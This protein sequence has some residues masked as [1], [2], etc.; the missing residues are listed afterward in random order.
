M[1]QLRLPANSRI[2]TGSQ[3]CRNRSQ[4]R[5]SRRFGVS[6]SFRASPT[7]PAYATGSAAIPRTMSRYS[8]HRPC[9]GRVV[10]GAAVHGMLPAPEGIGRQRHQSADQ[11]E[12]S[13]AE[14]LSAAVTRWSS[15][16]DTSLTWKSTVGATERVSGNGS[17]E[18]QRRPIP[19]CAR[20]H[21][22][23]ADDASDG[24]RPRSNRAPLLKRARLR[25]TD[26]TTQARAA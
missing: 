16:S 25:S 21:R 18:G 10:P 9:A 24:Y 26:L 4:P 23:T 3:L 5:R 1:V 11:L 13:R 7:F 2:R 15:A 8:A 22:G 19:D 6:G 12:L 20:W 17:I 14:V